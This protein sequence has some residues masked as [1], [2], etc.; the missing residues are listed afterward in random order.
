[1]NSGYQ[2]TDAPHWARWVTPSGARDQPVH[3]W[4]LFPH[5]FTGELVHALIDEWGLDGSDKLLDPFAGAGTTLVASKESGVPGA[6]YD[7]SPLAVFVSE[8]KIAAFRRSS[9]EDAWC[10]LGLLIGGT[11]VSRKV[12][13]Y[14]ALV[15]RAL[16]GGR[17]E[18]FDALTHYIDLLECG[19]AERAFFRLALIATIPQFSHARASGGWL[20]WSYDA[21]SV[22]DIVGAYRERVQ[23]MLDDVTDEDRDEKGDE[24]GRWSVAIGD[25]RALDNGEA[26]FSAVITS[27]PYP[28]R[29]D[30]TRV[31]GV[32]LMF[33]FVDWEENR[34]LRYQSF[35][36]HP[37]ARPVRPT[38]AGYCEPKGLAESI[39][40]IDDARLHRMCR[41]YFVDMFLCLKEIVRVCEPGARVA[42]VVGNAQYVGTPLIVDELTAEIGGQ[43]G[44]VCKEIR[45]AR[46]RGNSAQQMATYGRRPSRESVVMFEVV[47]P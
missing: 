37:E 45:T 4:Y 33:A 38:V 44:L 16:S 40:N 9:L 19:A 26:E 7:L 3:R 15:R 6:G 5:S 46:W 47:S 25:A 22:G 23:G 24:D 41:G 18:V 17:L 28:N 32:E 20:R 30:Y 12:E 27:P 11:L 29:H 42:L 1:M 10:R 8:T 43:A 34:D 36:S 39:A 13:R 35:H 2:V 21:G 14:P 31:F